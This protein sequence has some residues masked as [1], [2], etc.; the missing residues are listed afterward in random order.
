MNKIISVEESISHIKPGD[1]IMA[2]GFLGV[3][4][5]H[6]IIDALVKKGIGDLTLVCNDTANEQ[7][8]VGRMVANKQF[9]KIITSHIGTNKE[10]GRQLM[11]G[12]TEIELVPQ[13]TLAERVRAGGAGLGGVLTPTGV[14]TMVAEGKQIIEVNGKEYILE[15]PLRA[16]VAII[17]GSIVDKAGNVFHS[18]T[19]RN[20]NPLMAL[21]ADIVIV[22]AEKIVEVGEIDPHLVM[23]PAP[24]VDYIE[25]GWD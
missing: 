14:G 11:A 2:G 1:T 15:M 12:E 22:E 7:T 24:L 8:G 5:A 20:F 16:N 23:T 21:A 4:S 18:K 3:G 10:S 9:R 25:E 13:G 17:F 19:T 6:K